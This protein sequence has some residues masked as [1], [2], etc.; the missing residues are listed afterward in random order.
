MKRFLLFSGF[1]YYPSGGW[2]DFVDSF[3][4]AQEAITQGEKDN[5][6]QNYQ[7]AHVVDSETRAVIWPKD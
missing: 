3:A 6:R 4:T 1:D 2:Y 5:D 7:W